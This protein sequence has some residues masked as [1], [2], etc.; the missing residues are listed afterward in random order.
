MTPHPTKLLAANDPQKIWKNLLKIGGGGSCGMQGGLLVVF[1]SN[2]NE[3]KILWTSPKTEIIAKYIIH[4][5]YT[6]SIDYYN[7]K[8]WLKNNKAEKK[9]K[10]EV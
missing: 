10:E 2:I 7:T 4:S 1:E 3:K 9:R 5:T 8:Q 6:A